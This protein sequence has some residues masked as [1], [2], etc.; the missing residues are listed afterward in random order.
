MK[1]KTIIITIIVVVLIAII[2][3]VAS[4]RKKDPTITYRSTA[5]KISTLVNE[6]SASKD[7]SSQEARDLLDKINKLIATQEKQGSDDENNVVVPVYVD[8]VARGTIAKSLTYVGDVRAQTMVRLY[9][10][11]PDRINKFF[12]ENGDYVN[13]GDP[14]AQIENSRLKDAVNQA[15]AGLNTALAQLLNVQE[16]FKRATAL[17]E[18]KAMSQSQYDQIKTQKDVTEEAV[19]QARAAYTSINSSLADALIKAPIAG[20]IADRVLEEGDLAAG[21]I[22]IAN[23]Y[24]MD[25]VKVVVQMAEAE[26]GKIRIGMNATLTVAAYPNLQFRGKISKISPVIN[27]QTRTVEAEIEV[28]NTSQQLKPGMF[29][30]VKILLEE[31][32]N[33]LLIS[34]SDVDTKTSQISTGDGL[35]DS[36]VIATYS[37]F[38]I[39]DSLARFRTINVGIESDQVY[40]VLSGLKEGDRVVSVGRTILNDSTQVSIKN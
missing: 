39:Q 29:A 16:E 26:V 14:I 21:Q 10:K 7:P 34:K 33:T 35:R 27:P 17:Y 23:I 9:S 3:I 12:V 8:K 28:A 6:Y 13:V 19:K 2:A 11:V 24:Q 25:S 30:E 40:E 18:A 4:G 38:V 32:T 20:I 1:K 37:V 5:D 22:P 36:K 31:K 15:I